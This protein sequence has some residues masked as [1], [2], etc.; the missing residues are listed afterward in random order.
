MPLQPSNDHLKPRS[1]TLPNYTTTQRDLLIVELG[2]IIYNTTTS[3]VNV[4]DVGR[5]AGSGSWVVVTST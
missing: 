5:T 2:T 1:L 4:C 3:K